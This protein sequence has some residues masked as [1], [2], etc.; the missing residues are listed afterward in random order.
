MLQS[1][2]YDLIRLAVDALRE[3]GDESLPIELVRL[4]NDE[5]SRARVFAAASL[6]A[7][8]SRARLA[9]VLND[10][11]SQ[12]FYFYDVVAAIDRALYCC[13]PPQ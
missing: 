6:A 11:T 7:T 2:D 13:L 1:K 8:I 4:L 5:N 10:Y 12:P 9:E 3:A